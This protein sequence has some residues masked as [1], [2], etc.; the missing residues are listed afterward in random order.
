MYFVGLDACRKGWFAVSLG[1]QDNWKI[2]IYKTIGD[3]GKAFQKAT[4]IFIDIPIGLP[5]T[6]RRLC[7]LQTRK[8]LYRRASSVFPVPCREALAPKTYR[9]AVR[10]NQRVMGVGLSIQTWNISSKINEVDQW[11]RHKKTAQQQ[12][13]E[14][15]PELCF[16]AFAGG[17]PMAYSKK[18]P[19]GFA[20]RYAILKKICP[21][22]AAM[23]DLALHRFRRKDLARDDILDAIVLAVSAG[24]SAESIKTVPADPPRDKKG[25]SMEI[26]YAMP[27]GT[28]MCDERH[29]RYSSGGSRYR[30]S[31]LDS[32]QRFNR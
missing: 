26:V 18:S 5:E 14:S 8:I 9:S 19:Q 28:G 12:I 2:D 16:W 7:D 23:V 13:R 20:E 29:M 31:Y 11:L 6:G 4:L 24:Y 30:A 3:F 15:H 32:N 17:R 27:K 22:S 10:I 21:H 25:L 1:H